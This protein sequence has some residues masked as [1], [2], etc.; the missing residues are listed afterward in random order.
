MDDADLLISAVRCR[1]PGGSS[2]VCQ[3]L[4][5]RMMVADAVCGRWSVLALEGWTCGILT[6]KERRSLLVGRS[7]AGPTAAGAS[8]GLS[9]MM[10][11]GAAARRRFR[12]L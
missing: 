10:Q 8:R 1:I 11:R 4:S 2:E 12:R 6:S 7:C 9:A 5:R 3:W